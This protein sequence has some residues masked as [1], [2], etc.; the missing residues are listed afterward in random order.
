LTKEEY[1]KTKLA[2]SSFLEWQRR[3]KE[4]AAAP[5]VRAG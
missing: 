4:K 5:G 1:T 3:L 2:V